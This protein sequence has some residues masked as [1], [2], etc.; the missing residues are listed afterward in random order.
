MIRTSK[1]GNKW[2]IPGGKIERGETAEDAL[3]REVR[4]ETGLELQ[5][6]RFVMTQDCVDPAEFHRPAHFLLLNYA[7]ESRSDAVTLNHEAEEFRWVSPAEASAMD[8]NQP[9]RVLLAA[10]SPA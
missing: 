8:L 5:D 2:G 7:A 10:L 3:R 6:V 4:E 1:W 9:T